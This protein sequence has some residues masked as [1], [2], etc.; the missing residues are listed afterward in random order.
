MK[1]VFIFIVLLMIPVIYL[2]AECD[3][4]KHASNIE[5]AKNI[6]YDNTY[7]KSLRKYN[8][9]IYN[10]FNNMY[11]M[12]NKNKFTPNSEN[13]I[14]IS[15]VPQGSTAVI[16]IYGNDGCEIVKQFT[17][18]E[19]YYNEYY[20]SNVCLGYENKITACSSQFTVDQMDE[21]KIKEIIDNYNN[22]IDD[23]KKEEDEEEV[24]L[25]DKVKDFFFAW[26]LKILLF[27]LTCALF[28]P[29]YNEKLRRMKHGI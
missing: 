11:A 12:Y 14:T 24:S 27:V 2:N 15:G 1:R 3:Y 28:I 18:E 13:I 19:L 6:T 23:N 21:D 8:I 5:L 17:I 9:T 16:N 7:S 10:V 25:F 4:D 22:I 29:L 20:G 26:G